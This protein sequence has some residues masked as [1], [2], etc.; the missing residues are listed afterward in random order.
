MERIA[1]NKSVGPLFAKTNF[2]FK[3]ALKLSQVQHKE[4][5]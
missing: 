4:N 2:A 1:E 3:T 5:V